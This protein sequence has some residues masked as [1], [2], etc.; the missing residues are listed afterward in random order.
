MLLSTYIFTNMDEIMN[1]TKEIGNQIRNGFV[2]ALAVAKLSA[3]QASL[4]AGHNENQLN[5]FI[6]GNDIKL[7]TLLDICDAVGMEL[8]T[9]IELGKEI[10]SP[11]S[12]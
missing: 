7:V 2:R 10:E 6:A 1:Y 4:K 5:R 12:K 11:A 8:N 3:R 9:I